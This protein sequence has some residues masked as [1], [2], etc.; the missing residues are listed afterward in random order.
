MVVPSTPFTPQVSYLIKFV[1]VISSKN[2]V[3]L[4]QNIF[5][6]FFTNYN[7]RLPTKYFGGLSILV[8]M[9]NSSLN[10]YGFAKGVNH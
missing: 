4:L 7:T 10:F 5:A 3:T 9:E 2:H 1:A 6:I 8:L